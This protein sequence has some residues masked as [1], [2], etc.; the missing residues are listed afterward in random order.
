MD[1]LLRPLLAARAGADAVLDPI[2]EEDPRVDEVWEAT[3]PELH[4]ATVRDATFYRWRFLRAPSRVQ[5]AYVIL[6]RQRPIGICALQE[7]AGRL[8]I[9]D[10]CAPAARWGVALSAITRTAASLPA[11]EIAL[12]REHGQ[13]RAVW[14]HG[15][16]AREGHAFLV[17]TPEGSRR[18]AELHDPRRW[19]YMGGDSDVDLFS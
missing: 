7:R 8:H 16:V 15:F 11:V 17:V 1:P 4:I 3:R 6:R 5:R 18:L 2:R 19:V 10:L 12:L 13:A 9:V 14:R